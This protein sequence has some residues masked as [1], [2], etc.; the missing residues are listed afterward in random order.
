M[1]PKVNKNTL[2][3][4]NNKKN[5]K[6]APSI[7][8]FTT[9]VS[10]NVKNHSN[11]LFIPKVKDE[12]SSSSTSLQSKQQSKEN[13]PMIPQK[14]DNSVNS[15]FCR[16]CYE[17]EKENDPLLMP[18]RCEGSMK[19]IHKSCLKKCIV[20]SKKPIDESECEICKTKYEIKIT[21]SSEIDRAKL[22]Q[23]VFQSIFFV[24]IL[25]GIFIGFTFALYN[26]LKSQ[27]ALPEKY[28]TIFFVG[29]AFGS[30]IVVIILSMCLFKEYKQKCYV[31]GEKKWEIQ[32]YQNSNIAIPVN[33]DLLRDTVSKNGMTAKSLINNFVNHQE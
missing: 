10:N 17:P 32:N 24:I 3:L 31:I 16:I 23:F 28:H 29:M 5:P 15:N 4:N 18:C 2:T 6:R 19:Y 8:S 13:L 25:I 30:L 33:D 11:F 21:Q 9:Q 22:R 12:K 14:A 26:I 7:S 1:T 27:N 20:S